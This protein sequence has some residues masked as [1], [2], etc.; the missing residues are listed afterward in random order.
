MTRLLV[1][2]AWPGGLLLAF[3]GPMAGRL[4]FEAFPFAGLTSGLMVEPSCLLWVL[5]R[6]QNAAD[7]KGY[8][9]SWSFDLPLLMLSSFFPLRLIWIIKYPKDHLNELVHRGLWA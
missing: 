2:W 1:D 7:S 9:F 8:R 4:A 5:L 6:L 3:M